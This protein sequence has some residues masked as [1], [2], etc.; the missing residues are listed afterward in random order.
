MLVYCRLKVTWWVP[1]EEQELLTLLAH[2]NY[3]RGS[4]CTIF[5]FQCSVLYIIICPFSFVHCISVI[6]WFTASDYPFGIFCP[7]YFCHSL[8]Y[9][10]WLPLWYLLSIVFLS[11]FDLQLLITLLVSF[12]HCV[13]CP[14]IYSFWLPLWYLQTFLVVIGVFTFLT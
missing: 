7:L 14:L 2:T 12:G 4:R 13:V 3:F 6:L 9:S 1:L 8:I 11:F 5:S 10:F